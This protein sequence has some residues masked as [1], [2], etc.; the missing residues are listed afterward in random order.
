MSPRSM[1][2]PPERYFQKLCGI[3]IK[4]VDTFRS[5]VNNTT[6]IASEKVTKYGYHFCFS[7]I[8]PARTTGR[9]G[10]TQGA[11]IV[12]TPARNDTKKSEDI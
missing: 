11:S 9:T 3:S 1:S 10:R 12:R 8:L 7:Q 5:T 6:E 2:I 4:S